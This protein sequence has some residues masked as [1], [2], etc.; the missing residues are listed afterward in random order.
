M[1][2]ETGHGS[3][4]ECLGETAEERVKQ[5]VPLVIANG[6]IGVRAARAAN[7]AKFIGQKDEEIVSIVYPATP[8]GAMA[9]IVS[10]LS[11][12]KNELYS[13]FPYTA[14]GGERR[15][16]ILEIR[17]GGSQVEGVLLCETLTEQ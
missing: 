3:H 14:V 13:A 4:W 17:D 12:K 8:L 5:F 15:L 11:H 10:E 1:S 9:I 6:E 2:S 16:R 7:A